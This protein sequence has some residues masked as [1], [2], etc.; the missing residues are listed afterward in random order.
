MGNILR[1]VGEVLDGVSVEGLKQ[2]RVSVDTMS[3]DS[4]AE[5]NAEDHVEDLK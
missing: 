4:S 5:A 2:P 3:I 1:R